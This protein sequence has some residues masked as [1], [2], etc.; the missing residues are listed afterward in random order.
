MQLATRSDAEL[1]RRAQEGMAT[2]FAALVHR[3]APAVRATVASA[4]DPE[5]AVVATFSSAMRGLDH[6]DP[7]EPVAPW[8]I[9]LASQQVSDPAPVTADAAPPMD[10]DE[11]DRIWRELD[12]RWPS[13]RRPRRPPRWLIRGIGALALLAAL[14]ALA[15][16]GPYLALTT[17]EEQQTGEVVLDEVVAEP[18][19]GELDKQQEPDA[20]ADPDTGETAEDDP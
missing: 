17:A 5:A 12:R 20:G 11:L 14:L 7:D 1:V 3:H 15:V 6:R 4:A 9:E 2:A 18:Y 13:G 16:V 19:D 8:F 10:P